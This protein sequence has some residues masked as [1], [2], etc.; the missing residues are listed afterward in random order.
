V[1]RFAAA[2][3]RVLALDV[4]TAA[5]AGAFHAAPL[6]LLARPESPTDG[7]FFAAI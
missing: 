2:S 1:N 5:A 6:L 7:K 3:D 4:D